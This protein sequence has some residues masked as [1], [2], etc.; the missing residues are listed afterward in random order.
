MPII[1][2]AISVTVS[3]EFA[4]VV[5]VKDHDS[6]VRAD[7]TGAGLAVD[8]TY[9]PAK[10]GLSVWTDIGA[11]ERRLDLS[12]LS[13]IFGYPMLVE[14]EAIDAPCWVYQGNSTVTL[15]SQP[16]ARIQEDEYRYVTVTGVEEAY[17]AALRTSASTTSGTLIA[18]RIDRL[19]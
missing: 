14:V 4:S 8:P 10:I 17:I 16:R 3:G 9:A 15:P 19:A 13:G 11:V 18:T 2:R 5:E 1:D 7:V 12:P 6:E